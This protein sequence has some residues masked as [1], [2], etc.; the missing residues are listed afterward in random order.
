M[1][2]FLIQRMSQNQKIFSNW[3][4]SLI[5]FLGSKRKLRN[6]IKNFDLYLTSNSNRRTGNQVLNLL[7]LSAESHIIIEYFL[8]QCRGEK[9]APRRR[10]EKKCGL[11]EHSSRATGAHRVFFSLFSSYAIQSAVLTSAVENLD[12]LH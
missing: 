11:R 9:F 3:L 6:Q 5:R 8:P 1:T 7:S 2:R 10:S 4:R 12:I